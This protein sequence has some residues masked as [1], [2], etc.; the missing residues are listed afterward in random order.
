ME[1]NVTIMIGRSGAKRHPA[2]A[3]VTETAPGKPWNR[4]QYSKIVALCG[5]PFTTRLSQTGIR[6]VGQGHDHAD[7]GNFDKSA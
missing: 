2:Q 1:T 5:C 7:C 6:V 4:K 3:V